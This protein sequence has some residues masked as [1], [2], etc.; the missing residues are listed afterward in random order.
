MLALAVLGIVNT[1]LAYWLFYLL[2]DQ[3]GAATASVLGASG[4][5]VISHYRD[6]RTDRAGAERALAQTPEARKP[7]GESRC[8]WGMGAGN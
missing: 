1:G 6:D 2:I 3:A 4:A 5:H 8:S 7:A